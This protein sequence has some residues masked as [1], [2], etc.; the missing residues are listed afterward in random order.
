MFD[1]I[2]INSRLTQSKNGK[3]RKNLGGTCDDKIRK[4]GENG[5]DADKNPKKG[6]NKYD[7]DI[8]KTLTA[9]Q[10]WW[11]SLLLGL[12]FVVVSSPLLYF[13]TDFLVSCVA[14]GP[15]L[16]VNSVY[17]GYCEVYAGPSL[18][19]LFIHFVIFTLVIRFLLW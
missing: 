5:G 9:E 2:I 16:Y 17:N 14:C 13:I 12:L 11:V 6:D 8:E 7:P 4:K 15:R 3:I 19:G 10:K 1:D 18:L